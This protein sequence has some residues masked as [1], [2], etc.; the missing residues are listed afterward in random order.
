MYLLLLC[1]AVVVAAAHHH[2]HTS[3]YIIHHTI[4]TPLLEF[5]YSKL[6]DYLIVRINEALLGKSGKITK[7]VIG[8]LD[9]F[10][11]EIMTTNSLEQLCINYT[12]EKLQQQF[13]EH[14]FN[15]EQTEYKKEQIDWKDVPTQ[16]SQGVLDLIEKDVGFRFCVLVLFCSVFGCVSITRTDD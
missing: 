12:N 6:F 2:R 4:T 8:I 3:S 16:S 5:V 7:R 1:C 11:F 9:I 10:G 14:T 13:N 15:T